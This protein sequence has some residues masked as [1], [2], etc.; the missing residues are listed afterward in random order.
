MAKV[1]NDKKSLKEIYLLALRMTSSINFPIYA[2]ICFF[3]ADIIAI[4]LGPQ[5]KE[6]YFY[7]SIFAIWGAIR[8]VGNPTGSLLYSTGNVRRAFWWNLTLIFTTISILFF[9]LLQGELKGLS[10]GMLA[11][12]LI[13][14][15]PAWRYLVYPICGA[16]LNEYFSQLIPPFVA[17]VTSCLIAWLFINKMSIENSFLRICYSAIVFGL[18]Y[19]LMSMAINRPWIFAMK[20]FFNIFNGETNDK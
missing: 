10:I 17:A 1:Q 14:F 19:M 8:S 4:L 15:I 13:I 2:F 9:S 16:K 7:M 3:A 18:F 11:T 5:W 20:K 6:A 12:Q